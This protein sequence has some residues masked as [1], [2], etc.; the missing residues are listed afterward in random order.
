MKTNAVG[1]HSCVGA[2][3]AVVLDIVDDGESTL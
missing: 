2:Q 1:K 3:I